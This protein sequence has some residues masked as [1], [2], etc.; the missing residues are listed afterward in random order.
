MLVSVTLDTKALEAACKEVAANQFPFAASLAM[1]NTGFSA[2][3]KEREHMNRAF[4]IRNPNVPKFGVVMSEKPTKQNLNMTLQTSEQRTGSRGA[5][6]YLTKFEQGGAK[7]PIQGQTVAVPQLSVRGNRRGVVP[8][9]Y[10]IRNLQFREIGGRVVGKD[11]TFIIKPKSGSAKK[12]ILQSVGRG[13]SQR[14][15]VLYVLERSV[16]IQPELR[17]VQT[18][19]THA[20]QVWPEMWEQAFTQAMATRRP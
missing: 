14:N 18:V 17:F 6:D 5:F 12:L 13:K 15:R 19:T 16:P 20:R 1:R 4:V 11:R 2:L 10:R 7:R 3:D 9:R 8:N